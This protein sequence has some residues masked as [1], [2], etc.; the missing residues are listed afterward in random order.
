MAAGTF[1]LLLGI[2]LRWVLKLNSSEG[3]KASTYAHLGADQE[4]IYLP[5]AQEI[6]AQ[7]AIL[8]VS[9]ND[10]IEQRDAGQP[11]IAWRLVR[12][13]L[14]EWDRLVEILAS[15]NKLMASHLGNTQGMAPSRPVVPGRFKTRVMVD[16]LRMHELFDQLVFRSRLRF[17][18]HLRMLRRA[19]ETLTGEFRRSFRYAD[20]TGDQP[21]ELWERL[22]YYFHDLD[23]IAKETLLSFRALLACLPHSRLP[24]LRRD[25]QSLIRRGVRSKAMPVR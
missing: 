5:V 15:L 6:S 3:P 19:S 4:E 20:R 25:A 10:A 11:D 13:A 1:L 16:F 14:S 23:L 7:S 18:L 12:L 9:L 21:P 17:Q 24:E 22:D 2:V 8:G